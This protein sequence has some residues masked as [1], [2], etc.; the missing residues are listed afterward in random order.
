MLNAKSRACY[1]RTLILNFLLRRLGFSL[2]EL[3][4]QFELGFFH[5][6]FSMLEFYSK[7]FPLNVKS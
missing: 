4:I 6:T 3:G 7:L 2:I 5:N 1:N